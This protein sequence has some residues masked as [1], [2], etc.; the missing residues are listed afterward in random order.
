MIEKLPNSTACFVC[1]HGNASGLKAR[2]HTD[3][4][5][6]LTRFTPR[7]PQ[8]GYKG[9]THGG[10][11]A[12]LLDETMGWAPA[13]AN[14]RFCLT[15]EI[16]IQYLKPI[17]IGTEV[18]VSA[19]VTDGHRRIWEAEGE[20]RDSDGNLYARGKGRFL[21]V[22]DEQTREVVS[23]LNFDEGCVAPDRICRTCGSVE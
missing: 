9:I 19:W 8:M 6:V 11:I 22:S 1:G 7:E 13:L 2:F 12:A 3:G 14:R 10:V 17:P 15:V 23:Y 20:I 18:E 21:P 16:S 5:R 4:E